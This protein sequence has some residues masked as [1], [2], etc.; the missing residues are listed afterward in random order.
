MCLRVYRRQRS[1]KQGPYFSKVLHNNYH[2]V[3]SVKHG[4]HVENTDR[5][6]LRIGHFPRSVQ[7]QV[8]LFQSFIG[9]SKVERFSRLNMCVGR[10]FHIF[11]I[12]LFS[13]NLT[14]SGEEFLYIYVQ[15]NCNIW[16]S[17]SIFYPLNSLVLH[18]D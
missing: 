4:K 9:F 16:F 10:L 11:V 3:K 7:Q 6:I 13:S 8:T 1:R 14:C 17:R 12:K 18:S 5:K 15:M 2:C